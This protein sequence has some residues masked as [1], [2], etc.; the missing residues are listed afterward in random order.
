[1][2]LVPHIS[3]CRINRSTYIT[4]TTT[5]CVLMMVTKVASAGFSDI[6]LSNSSSRLRLKSL[7]ILLVIVIIIIIAIVL[8]YMADS[9][10]LWLYCKHPSDVVQ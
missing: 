5:L 6:V 1:M 9:S 2:L 4:I 10:R 7:P 3:F 8:V